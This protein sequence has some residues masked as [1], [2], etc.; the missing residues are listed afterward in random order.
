M[1]RKFS[2]LMFAMLLVIGFSA[3]AQAQRS[4]LVFLGERH[5]DGHMDSDKID[6]GRDNGTF[7]AI[8]FRVNGGAVNFD[9]IVVKYLNGETE[10][11]SVRSEIPSGGR[12]RRIDPR[13]SRRVLA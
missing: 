3:S 6:V 10:Q 7:R 9:R 13:G 4:R 12:T 1:L 2:A 11:M 5:I 8:Q